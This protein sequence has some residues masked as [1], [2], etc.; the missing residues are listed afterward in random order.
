VSE[1]VDGYK[2]RYS[3]FQKMLAATAAVIITAVAL[4]TIASIKADS[5]QIKKGMLDD[6]RHVSVFI[7]S[8]VQ[9]AF[10]SLNWIYVEE[11]LDETATFMNKQLLFVLV[12]KDNGEIY[13][14]SDKAQQGEQFDKSFLDEKGGL[15]EV[16][17]EQRGKIVGGE[18]ADLVLVKPVVIGAKTW[19][20]AL[21]LSL[22]P[23][24]AASYE[25]IRRHLSWAGLFLFIG[26]AVAYVVSRSI[27]RPINLLAESV[28][29]VSPDHLEFDV[30]INA[31]DEVGQLESSFR[32]MLAD[33]AKAH[34]RLE[35][36]ARGNAAIAELSRAII[37]QPSI[38]RISLLVLN[39]AR[40]LTESPTGFVGYADPQTGR[41]IASVILSESLDGGEANFSLTY[42]DKTAFSEFL[43]PWGYGLDN[44]VSVLS[45]V[46]LAKEGGEPP[47]ITRYIGAPSLHGSDLLGH[48]GVANARRDYAP[49]DQQLV[50]RIADLYA[51]A[52][53][54][55]RALESLHQAEEKYRG[56]FENAVEGIFQSSLKGSFLSANPAMA[57]IFDYDSPEALMSDV[58]D[59]G[60]KLYANPKGRED[61][62]RELRKKGRVTNY[63]FEGVKK[64]GKHVWASLSARLVSDDDV[65]F[66]EGMLIDVTSRKEKEQA[67]LER[68]AAEAAN[69][70][71]SD[72]LAR[73]SH[74]IRTPMNAI[75]GAAD[76]LADSDLN[77]RQLECVN[78]LQSSGENLLVL[79]NDILDLSKIEAGKLELDIRPFNVRR[80][81]EGVLALLE[82][83]AREKGLSLECDV[84]EAIPETLVGDPFRIRQILLNLAGNAVK[85]TDQGGVAL[86]VW[87]LE[88]GRDEAHIVFTVRDTGVGIPASVIDAIFDS[89]SQVDAS[90]T[91]KFG[92]SGLGL[93]ICK[94]LAELMGGEIRVE[95]EPGQGSAFNFLVKLG[96]A[97]AA[98]V[99]PS[100]DARAVPGEMDRPARIL[101]AEDSPPIRWLIANFLEN[102]RFEL[103]M[104]EN[105]RDALEKAREDEYDAVLMDMEMPVMDGYE[106]T[107]RIRA[108]ENERS[109]P[110]TPIIALTAHALVQD[111][112]RCLAAGCSDYLPKPVRRDQLLEMLRRHVS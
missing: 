86:A 4:W 43:A 90:T 98:E 30:E 51:I 57:R 45:N 35:E 68:E 75:V 20:V 103:D 49:G 59:I 22:E 106:A 53:Q 7:A 78:V 63:E 74:E 34:A 109:R 10:W 11:M 39:H 70:A 32:W 88:V 50:E 61:L 6:A 29:K 52:L 26:V 77:E 81:M 104:V 15:F 23:V 41:F 13:L 56:I 92:G 48:I 111:R 44:R 87:P 33:L 1:A 58:K 73:M 27:S 62:L 107:T 91:R 38:E 84:A 66:I 80:A 102:T 14:S 79:I 25:I 85:F 18:A 2:R 37:S 64:D 105:G 72:F 108:W 82:L 47:S 67:V 42:V 17:K 110:A 54:R 112:E 99:E 31:R 9:S 94:S 95:S 16:G 5:A 100:P 76:L 3:I 69:T 19:Y 36:D 89:F 12:A 60:A 8:S 97:R 83:R 28:Q 101:L 21:G 24:R 71:K 55:Q 93:T 65:E 96:I 40:N 46:P